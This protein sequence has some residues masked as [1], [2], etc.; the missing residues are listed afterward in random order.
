ME[1]SIVVEIIHIHA[2]Q[3]IKP[4]TYCWVFPLVFELREPLVGHVLGGHV[5]QV[6]FA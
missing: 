3:K 6:F 2:F 1:L 5:G 4:S